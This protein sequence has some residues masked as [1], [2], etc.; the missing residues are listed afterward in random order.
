M[1]RN[2]HATAYGRAAA[3]AQRSLGQRCGRGQ[4]DAISFNATVHHPR[5]T[6]SFGRCGRAARRNDRATDCG[7]RIEVDLGPRRWQ[8]VSTHSKRP[9]LFRG[10]DGAANAARDIGPRQIQLQLRRA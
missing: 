6:E 8:L 2:T 1:T 3:G 9:R 7:Y 5:T 10:L 4:D